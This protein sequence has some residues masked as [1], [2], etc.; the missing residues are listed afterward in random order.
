MKISKIYVK[1]NNTQYSIY[2]GTGA[3]N[4]LRK[5]IKKL[6]PKTKKIGLILDKNIPSKF[7]SEI[8][9]QLKNY[10]VFAYEYLPNENLKS[11]NKANNL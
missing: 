10:K 2:I 11:F 3:L 7:K 4:I 5:Q 9:K 1:N 6:C 8:K